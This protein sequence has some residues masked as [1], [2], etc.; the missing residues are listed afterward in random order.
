MKQFC[1]VQRRKWTVIK[2]LLGYQAQSTC[3]LILEI[4]H[5]DMGI[6]CSLQMTKW[7]FWSFNKFVS[8][9]RLAKWQRKHSNPEVHGASSRCLVLCTQSEAEPAAWEQKTT[10]PPLLTLTPN[11]R[12]CSC[13]SW[14]LG[15]LV[16]FILLFPS[17]IY[18]FIFESESY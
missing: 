8:S 2:G 17:F 10:L 5:W 3:H 14:T 6:I 18:S 12:I 16:F 1:A 7:R 13:A 9:H 15:S 11:S 4:T